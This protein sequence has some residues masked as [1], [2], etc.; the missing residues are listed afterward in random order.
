MFQSIIISSYFVHGHVFSFWIF[1]LLFWPRD[2]MHYKRMHLYFCVYIFVLKCIYLCECVYLLM[3][4][5]I[6]A[7][8]ETL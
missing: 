7:H 4:M 3:S 6:H 8:T 2:K 5:Y 1:K